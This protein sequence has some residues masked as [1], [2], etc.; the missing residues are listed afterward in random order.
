MN[1]ILKTKYGNDT[2]ED[3]AYMGHATCIVPNQQNHK[4]TVHGN[5]TK[6]DI[7][8]ALCYCIHFSQQNSFKTEMVTIHQQSM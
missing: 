6:E 5:D 7:Q 4:M 2:K 1:R 3:I 8:L